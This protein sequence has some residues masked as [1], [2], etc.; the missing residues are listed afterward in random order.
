VGVEVRGL[1]VGVAG[2]AV[3]LLVFGAGGACTN[4]AD[5]T[6]AV[7]R[8]CQAACACGS[9][10]AIDVAPLPI[11]AFGSE[12]ACLQNYTCPGVVANGGFD[13]S[14]C[15]ASVSTAVCSSTDGGP[16]IAPS[17]AGPT[18]RDGIRFLPVPGCLFELN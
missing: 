16:V 11:Q 4:D 15:S 10:C 6:A 2:L 17:D 12:Q 18:G 7:T 5:C 9:E 14:A 13:P 1:V 8:L 3:A